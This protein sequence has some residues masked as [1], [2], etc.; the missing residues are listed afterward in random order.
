MIASSGKSSLSFILQL[1]QKVPFQVWVEYNTLFGLRDSARRWAI[2]TAR[3]SLM[4]L[5]YWGIECTLP[6]LHLKVQTLYQTKSQ[7]I[8]KK[9]FFRLSSSCKVIEC[10]LLKYFPWWSFNIIYKVVF[11]SYNNIQID[12]C[13]HH[14]LKY[15]YWNI[16]KVL[17]HS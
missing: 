5:W 6:G 15:R 12:F 9:F 14:Q 8:Y 13:L 3:Q 10:K 2:M 17:Y 4:S 1:S 16:F 7:I 11:N